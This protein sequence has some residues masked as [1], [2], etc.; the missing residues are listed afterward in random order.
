VPADWAVPPR[1]W[2]LAAR[3][4]VVSDDALLAIRACDPADP[5]TGE[6]FEIPGG[7]VEDGETTADAALR[8]TA[9][10][11]GYRVPPACVGPVCW[12]GETTYTW[13]GRRHWA[14]MVMHLAQVPA[15]PVRGPLAW[16]ETEIGTFQ[17]TCWLPLPDVLAG[18]Y[19]FFP[20]TLATDLPRVLAGEH[21]DTG[22]TV[23]S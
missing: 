7:G 13:L 15:R 3:L 22:F 16:Q 5:A 21:V 11:T 23:W 9:E 6:W 1:P 4:M 12:R 14:E 17:A 2:R 20:G 8:E 10:E 18:R 19:R